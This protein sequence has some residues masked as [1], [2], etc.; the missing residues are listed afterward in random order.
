MSITGSRGRPLVWLVMEQVVRQ[1]GQLGLT[2]CHRTGASLGL[3]PCHR[4]G[5]SLGLS[6]CHRSGASLGSVPATAVGP[7]WGHSLPPQWGQFGA[8]SLPPQWGQLG[9]TPCH[10]TSCSVACALC[11]LPRLCH[12]PAVSLGLHSPSKH[13]PASS[14]P[15]FRRPG[16]VT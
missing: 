16:Y 1:W 13:S 7:A 14:C 3:S 5:A 6:P 4:S 11:P 10:V 15:V 2:P 12:Q 8:H 9:L